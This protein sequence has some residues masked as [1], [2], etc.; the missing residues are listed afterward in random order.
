MCQPQ[1]MS[2]KAWLK[3]REKKEIYNSCLTFIFCCL[4]CLPIYL[5][6]LFSYCF[7]SKAKYMLFLLFFF[8]EWES[9]SPP[10][11]VTCSEIHGISK[12]IWLG[13]CKKE[14]N[15][16]SGYTVCAYIKTYTSAYNAI[17]YAQR[18]SQN[19]I[20]PHSQGY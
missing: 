9:I 16:Y 2:V 6:S 3:L 8:K 18:D 15:K 14:K 20:I 13:L 1:K 17:L 4:L 7:C 11:R 19:F 12:T 10:P 5:T